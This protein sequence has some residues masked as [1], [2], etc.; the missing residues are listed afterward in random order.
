MTYRRRYF[1]KPQLLLVLDLLLLDLTN[2]RALAFQLNA[3]S[4]HVQQLPRDLKAPRPTREERLVADAIGSLRNADV[5]LM[6]VPDVNG[7]F[8]NLTAVIDSL[9]DDFRALSDA[10]TYFYFSHAELRVS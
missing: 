9:D 6:S 2:T 7:Q 4:E 8:T 10:L 5:D 3:L 1:A